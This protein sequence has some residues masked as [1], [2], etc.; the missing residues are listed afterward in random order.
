[1][2]YVLMD[3]GTDI[4]AVASASVVEVVPCAA[5]KTAPGAP[6]FIAGILNYRATPVPVVDSGMLLAGHPAAVR[7][8]TRIILLR[9]EMGARE[10]VLGLLGENVTRVQG[11]EESDFVEPGARGTDFP[12]AG[13]I[14]ALGDR[15]VQRLDL[16]SVLTEEVWEALTAEEA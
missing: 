16:A 5:L 4:Y 6:R 1:M 12:C 3:A 9:L 14:A 13:R 11:F 2:L 7:F 8:S 15:W 10:R